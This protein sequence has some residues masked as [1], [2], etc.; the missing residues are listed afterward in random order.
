VTG[1]PLDAAK[2]GANSTVELF[3][4]TAGSDTMRHVRTYTH[5]IIET[6][7]RVAWVNDHAFV[8]SNDHSGKT[9]FVRTLP[10]LN[11][12]KPTNLATT[13]RPLP[14]W[15]KH[16]LLRPQPLQHR[17]HLQERLR[18]TE[19]PRTR[20]RRPHLHPLYLLRRNPRLRTQRAPHA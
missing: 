6:P 9:G 14:R 15:R 20:F 17:P 7:N 3:Q 11:N 2:V 10:P 8:F 19:R 1:D 13:S 12:I 16:R 5:E 18:D 4:T